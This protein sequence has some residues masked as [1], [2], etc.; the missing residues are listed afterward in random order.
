VQLQ[1]Q[2]IHKRDIIRL[3]FRRRRDCDRCHDFTQV[4]TELQLHC[5]AD[6]STRLLNIDSI[7]ACLLHPACVQL[8]T[9]A[10]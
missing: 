3:E 9:H 10:A 2:R 7:E 4:W 1:R 6:D 8:I 5:Y